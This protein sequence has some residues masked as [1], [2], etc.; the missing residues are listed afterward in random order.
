MSEAKSVTT[1]RAVFL[2]IDASLLAL[3][4]C[5]F[6]PRIA[7]PAHSPMPTLKVDGSGRSSPH[8]HHVPGH[9]VAIYFLPPPHYR[10]VA[11]LDAMGYGS[12]Y[13]R[14][15]GMD[16]RV[17]EHLRRQASRLGANGVLMERRCGVM[18]V[19]KSIGQA[20]APLPNDFWLYRAEAIR[21][22]G[23]TCT[24]PSKLCDWLEPSRSVAEQARDSNRL[25]SLIVVSGNTALT[26][27]SLPE[28]IIRQSVGQV[29]QIHIA[30]SSVQAFSAGL[31]LEPSDAP[32][33][34][35]AQVGRQ[36][37]IETVRIIQMG[38]D[39][40]MASPP[41]AGLLWTIRRWR[42]HPLII[43][44]KPQ[45]FDA[46]ILLK[47]IGWRAWH[48]RHVPYICRD[49]PATHAWAP[50]WYIYLPKPGSDALPLAVAVRYHVHN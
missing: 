29:E 28:G 11:R 43:Q 3:T 5:A 30:C 17:L 12:V 36:G 19:I 31:G 46:L 6:G 40:S 39:R 9:R 16:Y 14:H 13:G 8:H 33:R 32:T 15:V 45:A 34:I 20:S 23:P 27:P 2:M 37:Q 38:Q 22:P 42:F 4:G 35:E 49:R 1:F 44:G 50:T 48:Q 26:T 24:F 18:C 25:T 47:S 21:V 41:P 10:V 7:P